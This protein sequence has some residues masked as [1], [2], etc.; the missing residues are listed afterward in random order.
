M[1]DFTIYDENTAPAE[2]R[3]T[4]KQVREG[5]GFIPNVLGIVAESNAALTGY[6][7]L[8]ELVQAT[9][10]SPQEQQVVILTVSRTNECHYCVAAHSATA[11]GAKVDD[12]VIDAI[13]E[14]RAPDDARLAALVAFTRTVVDKRG[15]LEQADID[16]FL[17]AG[18]TK[19][20]IFDVILVAAMKTISN[21]S[22]HIAGTP[23]DEAFA[24]YRWE[25]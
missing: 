16:A 17:D 13:R 14:G 25:G 24:D 7:K 1:T 21:Y 22:N 11:K 8:N 12:H 23:V 9:S 20:N 3:D 15:W 10:L 6:V 18:Y 19:A 5:F 4:L 2:S